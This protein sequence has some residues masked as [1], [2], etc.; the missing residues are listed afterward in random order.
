M[1]NLAPDPVK[2]KLE[3]VFEYASN[4]RQKKTQNVV[5]GT[6]RMLRFGVG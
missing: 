1:R 6:Y 2:Y 5:L 3:T 4:I